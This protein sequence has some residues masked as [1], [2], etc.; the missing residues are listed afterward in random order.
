M[1]G[2]DDAHIHLQSGARPMRRRPALPAADRRGDP[3]RRSGRTRPR[4]PDAPWVLG[5]GWLYAPFPGGLPDAR[6]ARPRRP[7]PAGVHGLLRRPHGLGEH[8]RPAARRHRP[9]DARPAQRRRSSATPTASPPAPSRR[10]RSSL[11]ERHIP[12]PAED[13]DRASVRRAIAGDARDGPHGGT[14]RLARRP[15][16]SRSG[17]AST[18]PASSRSGSGGALIMEPGQ[19]LAEWRDRLDEYEARSPSRSAAATGSTPGSSRAS[20]TA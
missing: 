2:F 5:R 14:G 16:S 1:P 6:A 20:W 18:P 8:R 3:G 10:T 11:V 9:R 19:T 15:T 7:G 13:E 12:V 17:G 4:T